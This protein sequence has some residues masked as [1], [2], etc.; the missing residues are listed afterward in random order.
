M[1]ELLIVILIISILAGLILLV[2]TSG[3]ES[4]EATRIL[5]DLRNIKTAAF[6]YYADQ[7]SWPDATAAGGSSVAT[8]SIDRYMDRS[9]DTSRYGEVEI[10]AELNNRQFIGFALKP[11]INNVNVQRKILSRAKDSGI[12]G[13]STGG[14]FAVVAPDNA[15]VFMNMR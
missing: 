12:F 4:A 3:L 10:G 13:S 7:G 9:L 11:P 6:M 15:A 1:V 8:A 5:N 14:D 2:S